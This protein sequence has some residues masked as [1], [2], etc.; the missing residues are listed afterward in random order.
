MACLYQFLYDPEQGYVVFRCGEDD[1]PADRR[2]FAKDHKQAVFVS[3]MAAVDYCAYRN[4][5][6][7]VNGDDRMPTT[8][9]HS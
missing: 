7:D 4:H 9:S 1:R 8:L 3:E 5:Y 2:A 6:V